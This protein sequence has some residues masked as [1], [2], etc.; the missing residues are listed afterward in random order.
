MKG[1][2]QR[3]GQPALLLDLI[4]GC[5]D[6]WCEG[7]RPLEEVVPVLGRC[8]PDSSFAIIPFPPAR[9]DFV[10]ARQVRLL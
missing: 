10:P 8:A 6:D 3:R 7:L 5:V 9:S 4:G 2:D 1:G